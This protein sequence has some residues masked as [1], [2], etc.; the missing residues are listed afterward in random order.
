[1]MDRLSLS[2]DRLSPY[3]ILGLPAWGPSPLHTWRIRRHLNAIALDD[4]M[5]RREGYG[6]HLTIPELEEALLERGM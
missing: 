3:S 6:R 4:E 1:M 2:L 5:L